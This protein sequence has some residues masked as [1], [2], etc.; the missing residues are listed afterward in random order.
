MM[1]ILLEINSQEFQNQVFLQQTKKMTWMSNSITKVSA[2][3]F[4]ILQSFQEKHSSE[5][6]YRLY[7]ILLN[8]RNWPKS[9]R[10]I[11]N[12]HECYYNKSRSLLEFSWLSWVKIDSWILG[13]LLSSN[14]ISSQVY[15]NEISIFMTCNRWKY[16]IL[17]YWLWMSIKSSSSAQIRWTILNYEDLCSSDIKFEFGHL[18]W[19]WITCWDKQF[20]NCLV[21][22]CRLFYRRDRFLLSD[23]RHTEWSLRSSIMNIVLT[24]L[25]WR[26]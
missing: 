24:F 15:C 11:F 18:I 3:I 9:S 12:N 26:W 4:I 8:K 17:S 10:I 19:W 13:F 14:L 16:F 1:K 7:S 21:Q 23:W 25:D 6:R 5:N 20:I 22:W 2:K